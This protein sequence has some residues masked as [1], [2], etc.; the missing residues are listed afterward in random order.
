MKDSMVQRQQRSMVQQLLTQYETAQKDQRIQLLEK[1]NA[2]QLMELDAHTAN[3]RL[4][5]GSVVSLLI[6]LALVLVVV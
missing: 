2:L 3:N 6:I 5:I 4:L 1:D